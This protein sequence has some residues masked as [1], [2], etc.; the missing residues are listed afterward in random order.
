MVEFALAT[1]RFL[2]SIGL[3][4]R[5]E[6]ADL[7]SEATN[8][9]DTMLGNLEVASLNL[10]LNVAFFLG[11]SSTLVC[12]QESVRIKNSSFGF[13]EAKASEAITGSKLDNTLVDITLAS[14]LGDIGKTLRF[15]SRRNGT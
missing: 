4:A 2:G 8:F 14:E 9:A 15:K 11:S 1:N 13:L 10:R 3:A 12:L 6:F 7:A 5:S